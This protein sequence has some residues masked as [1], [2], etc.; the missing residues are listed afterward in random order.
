LFT[1][2]TSTC[3]V[4]RS[5]L[6][7]VPPE[8]IGIDPA[9]LS[10]ALAAYEYLADCDL[11][12]DHSL[13][14]M[15]LAAAGGPRV[16]VV[17]TNHGPF[18]REMVDLYR[19]TADRVPLIAVSADQAARAPEGV[20][21]ATVI[22]HGVDLDRYRARTERAGSGGYLLCL[23]RMSGDKGIDIAI[24][25]ARRSGRRLVIAARMRG[26]AE[27]AYFRKVIEPSLDE[28]IV[29]VGEA[30]HA[31]KVDLLRGADALLNPIRWPE[32]FGL[33]MIEALACGTPVIAAPNGSAAEIVTPGLNGY[34]G[35]TIDD[36]TDAVAQ[37]PEICRRRCR[38]DA[39]GRFSLQAMAHE[40]E[41]FYHR[42]LASD[43]PATTA[44]Q[45]HPM[46]NLDPPRLHT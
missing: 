2:G 14:G 30:D 36:L 28:S 39:V 18:S 20:P 35:A 33:V 46:A 34:L 38:R 41:Q 9:G 21:V 45:C 44:G 24:E 40:H 6:H 23:A 10:H 12:H 4:D 37:I 32:P 25:V 1:V 19:R 27:V 17:T 42:V 16:P 8:R 11:I 5:W 31:T 22:H 3:P 15:T 43:R 26:D 7:D 29:Y 13:A